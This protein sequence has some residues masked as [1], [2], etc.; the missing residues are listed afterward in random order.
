M[1]FIDFEYDQHRLSDFGFIVCNFE[2][3]HGA[4]IVSIG[5]E[6]VMNTVSSNLGKK[7]H[8]ISSQ[9]NNCIES[10]FDICKNP[11]EYDNLKIS[12]DEYISVVRWLNRNKFMKFR[13]IDKCQ[14]FNDCYYYTSFNISKINI[15][16]VLYGL[17]L[18]MK[19]NR[20][21]ALRDET[22][23][24]NITEPNQTIILIDGSDDEGCIYPHMR[25]TMGSTDGDLKI[26]N[27]VGDKTETMIIKNCTANEVITVDYPIIY[28]SVLSHK[29]QKDFNW[30]FFGISNTN[31]DRVNK[32]TVSLPC[33]IEMGYSPAVKFGL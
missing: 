8:F 29:I 31:N 28:S 11:D 17:R 6:I 7:N 12:E 16:D 2:Q 21:F 4:D 18:T 5:S 27:E 19:T 26:S 23:N 24:F 22:Y 32:I 9:Y 20:P 30:K 15:G 3:S 25:I 10:E 1:R 13:I 33:T 14:E